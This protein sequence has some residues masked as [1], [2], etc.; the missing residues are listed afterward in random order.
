MRMRIREKVAY[1]LLLEEA[2]HDHVR[3]RPDFLHCADNVLT[4]LQEEG[5]AVPEGNGLVDVDD[6]ADR[7]H[8][9]SATACHCVPHGGAS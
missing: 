7:L 8:R 3:R 4:L 1:L 5:I 2:T 6:L 9:T